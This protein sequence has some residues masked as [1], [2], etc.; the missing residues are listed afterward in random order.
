VNLA[1]KYRPSTFAEVTGQK[2]AV[3]PL[4]RM[5]RLGT[6]PGALLLA[7]TRGCGKTSTA[8]I[9]GAALN[10]ESED[11]QAGRA[12]SARPAWRLPRTTPWT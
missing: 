3:V 12:V 5:A 7:G 11:Q 10:C 1:L 9:L 8:R 4:Y 2:L 6:V